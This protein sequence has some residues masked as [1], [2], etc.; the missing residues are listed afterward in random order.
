GTVSTLAPAAAAQRTLTF[1]PCVGLLGDAAGT[2]RLAERLAGEGKCVCVITNTVRQAQRV[3]QELGLDGDEKALFH[4][5]VTA[6]ERERIA[7]R[8]IAKF[9]KDSTLRPARY[10]LVATQVVEQSLDV[11]FDE[12]VS[13]IAPIDLLLQRSGRIKRHTRD[14]KGRLKDGEDERGEPTL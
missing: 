4:A 1:I 12:M 6:G 8:V 10:V 9:G 13:E 3:F 7:Q 2:A 14:A 5:R 11:D